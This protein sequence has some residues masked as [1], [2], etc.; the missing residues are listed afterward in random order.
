MVRIPF[1][2]SASP[3]DDATILAP[4]ALL[5]PKIIRPLPTT[6]AE[7]IARSQQMGR[8]IARWDRNAALSALA[9]LQLDPRLHVHS[10][11]LY[12]A[13]RLVAGLA[14]GGTRPGRS[15]LQRLLNSDFGKSDISRFEDPSEDLFLQTVSTR[16]GD[17][18][19]ICGTW[20]HP[21]FYTETLLEAAER[22]ADE[23]DL[24]ILSSAHALLLLSDLTAERAGLGFRVAGSGRQWA[25]VPL[26]PDTR[27]S[28][29][30]AHP[31]WS[32]SALASANLEPALLERFIIEGDDLPPT[33]GSAAGRAA[34]DT[35]PLLRTPTGILLAVPA[36]ISMAVRASIVDHMLETD[37]E[38]EIG[39]ALLAV[40]AERLA[41]TGFANLEE[42][43]TRWSL[44]E[45]TRSLV[46]EEAPGRYVH[47]ELIAGR[48]SGWREPGFGDMAPADP[49]RQ[50]RIISSMRSANEAC[51]GRPGFVAGVTVYLMGGWGPGEIIDFRRPDDL[52]AWRFAGVEVADAMALGGAK[53]GTLT[54]FWR[55]EVLEDMVQSEGIELQNLSGPLNLHEWWRQTDHTLVPQGKRDLVPPIKIAMP[56]DSLFE[57]RKRAADAFDRRSVQLP[58]GSWRTVGRLDPIADFGVLEPIYASYREV[59]QGTLLGAVLVGSSP[60]WLRLKSPDVPGR[61]ND[62]YQNWKAALHWMSLIAD[63]VDHGDDASTKPVMIDLRLEP[64]DDL[65]ATL[66]TD[67]E[68]DDA[69]AAAADLSERTGNVSAS[70][71]WQ[72][73]ARRVDNR[74]EIALAA[75]LLEA[76]QQ[77]IGNRI[78]RATAVG[79]VRSKVPSP[80]IRWR[81]AYYP[82]R[83]A[84]QLRLHQII[85]R[86]FSPV[87]RS[88]VSIVKQGH[89][90]GVGYGPGAVIE[91]REKCAA[92]LKSLHARTLERLLVSVAHYDRLELVTASLS[93]LQ[94]SI[95]D[96]QHWAVTARALRGIHGA[97]ADGKVSLEHRNATNAN[98]RACAM[99]AEVAASHAPAEGGS[100]VGVMDLDEL[101]AVALQ[102]FG[103]CE[104][105]P[106]LMGDRLTPR[107]VISP[108]GDL[109]Y[110]HSFGMNTLTPS[111]TIMHAESRER[112]IERY[113]E[114]MANPRE[115]RGSLEPELVHALEAE[116]HCSMRT[117]GDLSAATCDL[118]IADHRDVIILRRSEL[119][120]RLTTLSFGEGEAVK[121]MIE[122]L[123]LRSR[124]GWADIPADAGPNDYDLG[125][126]DRPQSIIGR[127]LV[128]I[129]AEEDPMIAAAPAVV[130]R[131]AIHNLSGAYDGSLQDRF[132]SSKVM[133]SHVGRASNAAGNAFNVRVAETLAALGLDAAPGVAPWAALN[134]KA[135]PEMKLLGDIDV[136]AFSQDRL[137]VWV[138]EAKDIKLCRTLAETAR[139]LSEYRG[140]PRHDNKPD[141]LMRHL[142]RAAH[143]RENAEVLARRYKMSAVPVVHGLVVVD[144]PQPMAFVETNPSPDATFVRLKDIGSVDWSASSKR[145]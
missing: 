24:E 68:L 47:L 9:A 42:V 67:Q 63:L 112:D 77:A 106:A 118:A 41:E 111:S 3:N 93:L 88:A 39:D 79:R 144:S 73:G 7:A 92:L 58:D 95:A 107:L 127:P 49:K 103:Y 30:A 16:H 33:I 110:D 13:S 4:Q 98:L 85:G 116:F 31:N 72:G 45:A 132:W 80:D 134:Q 120:Q 141:N 20:A 15:D 143:I 99:L 32:A 104:L 70:A 53:D 86:K 131:A 137:H 52:S 109:L 89:A 55:L 51:Q 115:E 117:F 8:R 26:P 57:A 18:R 87:P 5:S 81:H 91:G 121:L 96:E 14:T 119:V 71:R 90:F 43:P 64:I 101:R 142:K 21:A 69:V 124:D 65:A 28:A 108:T 129:D 76:I 60:I 140:V 25:K 11:R 138:I 66:P 59:R 78:D 40:Q 12:W 97:D 114:R 139:R 48:F 46:R 135:T 54:D 38:Q 35:R 105:L 37:R 133:R 61:F 74:A 34:L 29:L 62:G 100:P 82:E 75:G 125:R 94:A 44:G 126:F 102:H 136:L 122:R 10:V 84:D 50:A 128:A 2:D 36:A 145:R 23:R 123:T 56:T 6:P 83:V 1:A 22:I 130:E 19:L 113:Q 17:R 27:L